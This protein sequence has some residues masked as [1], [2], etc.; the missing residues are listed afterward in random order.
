MSLIP[1]RISISS[2]VHEKINER[3]WER[4]DL[5]IGIY[6]TIAV[7]ETNDTFESVNIE[8]DTDK[9]NIIIGGEN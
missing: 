7:D 1:S 2:K 8:V 5:N 6:N 4:V 3:W 9:I